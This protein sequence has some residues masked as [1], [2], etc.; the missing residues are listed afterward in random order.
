M[1]DDL[2]RQE[3]DQI[4]AHKEEIRESLGEM[5]GKTDKRERERVRENERD[6]ANEHR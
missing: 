6:P 3:D 1:T 5:T 2:G 4:D